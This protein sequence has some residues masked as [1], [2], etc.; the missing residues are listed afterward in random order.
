MALESRSETFSRYCMVKV[1]VNTEAYR[2]NDSSETNIELCYTGGAKVEVTFNKDAQRSSL[3][4][5]LTGDDELRQTI[6]AL[7]FAADSL[8][9]L[10]GTDPEPSK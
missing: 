7:R 6:K 2:G 8:E 5:R 3:A 10:A 1:E 4:I 9:Q